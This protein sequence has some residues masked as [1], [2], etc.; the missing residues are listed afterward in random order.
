MIS[1]SLGKKEVGHLES[2]MHIT[3]ETQN[4]FFWHL[5][6]PAWAGS[7][8]NCPLSK[9]KEVTQKFQ[10]IRIFTDFTYLL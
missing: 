3:M 9:M 7:I 8:A 5:A 6:R 1:H 10:Y 2:G 4:V